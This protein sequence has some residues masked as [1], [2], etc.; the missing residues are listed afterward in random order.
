MAEPGIADRVR[1]VI[2]RSRLS[3][4]AF[5]AVIDME[6]TKL[7]KSLS[8]SRRFTSLELALIA[9]S[10]QVSVDWLLTG[11]EDHAP[12]MAARVADGAVVDGA[13]V[14][15]AVVNDAVARAQDYDDVYEVLERVGYGKT[16]TAP[17]ISVGQPGDRFVDQGTAMAT[18]ARRAIETHGLAVRAL[19]D[20]PAVVETVFGIDV[21][22]ESLPGAADG[23][24]YSRDGFRLALVSNRK[25]WTRQ[26][27]TLA[28]EVGHI[29]AGDAQELQVD[30]NV[31]SSD[32][33]RKGT[34]IR[35][36]AFAAELL[37]PA[38]LVRSTL[39]RNVDDKQFAK[40]VGILGV[41]PS[42]LAL[43]CFNLGLIDGGRRRKLGTLSAWE[44]AE[45]GGWV[46]DHIALVQ[47]QTMTRVPS[48]LLD[49]AHRAYHAGKISARPL[50][51]ILNITA[52]E[53]L[54]GDELELGGATGDQ[55]AFIP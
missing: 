5:A 53:F 2:G 4:A 37:M 49:R 6:P 44:A 30:L 25:S 8:G 10:A 20:L 14:D 35:A 26:R 19:R 51:T 39:A 1:E 42:A 27:F 12:K 50:A 46:E 7:S 13:V 38:E 48:D 11:R 36:N 18:A 9:E 55:P 29:L 32:T 22:V 45:L 34:E 52:E 16:V 24:S 23:L 33:E 15:G 41:S 3:Q 40:L 43:R 17:R 47:R 54:E 21:G 28:H 31:L